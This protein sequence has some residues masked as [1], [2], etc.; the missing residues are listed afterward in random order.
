MLL[1]TAGSPQ[2][3]PP[4]P[5]H[6]P[7][8]TEVLLNGRVSGTQGPGG[9]GQVSGQQGSGMLPPQ[10]GG[11]RRAVFPSSPLLRPQALLT[12][13]RACPLVPASGPPWGSPKPP[14]DS[15]FIHKHGSQG[16]RHHFQQT[17]ADAN[18]SLESKHA[19]TSAVSSAPTSWFP[20][21]QHSADAGRAGCPA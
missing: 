9:I 14:S 15:I 8:A 1:L 16:S 2:S 10:G 17:R 11:L 7:E 6:L 12:W 19:A 13:G 20:R 3:H 18:M 21:R 5:S 4:G